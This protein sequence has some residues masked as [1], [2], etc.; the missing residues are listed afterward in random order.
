MA[1]TRWGILSTGR[2]ARKFATDFAHVEGG[3]LVAVASRSKAAA[4]EFA[5]DFGIVH[6]FGSY[7]ELYA[8]PDIDAVYVATPHTLHFRNTLDAFDAGKAVLCEKP[9]TVD[10]DEC[11]TLI[12]R[13]REG[14]HYLMEAMW[15]YF[16]PAVRKA[17]EWVD[18]GRIG[19]IRHVKADF[20]FRVP[21]DPGSRLYNV[22]LAGGALLDMGIYPI[23]IAWFFMERHPRSIEVIARMAPNGVDD[24]VVMVFDFDEALATL[25]TSFRCT[26]PNRA[27]IVGEDAYIVLPD[28]WCTSE[29][30]L[31]IRNEVVDHYKHR[32][33][34]IGLDFETTAVNSDLANGRT[35]SEVVPLDVSLAFQEQMAQ[36]RALF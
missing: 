8:S 2:I 36:V 22:D 11:R 33:D 3:D 29:C 20:G 12:E 6:A 5:S 21:Y 18:A 17:K 32:R 23:A 4:D 16:L 10:P 19:A 35:E 7:E 31:C 13:S 26:L 1:N 34:S 15:T 25:S 14:N 27:F 30:L 28:F 9:L 24:D